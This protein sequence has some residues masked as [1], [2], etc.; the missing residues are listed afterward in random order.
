MGVLCD[1][2]VYY[3]LCLLHICVMHAHECMGG[4]HVHLWSLEYDIYCLLL[5]LSI[6]LPNGRVS[7]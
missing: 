5:S 4:A 2:S 3:M 7:H 6:L 1:V